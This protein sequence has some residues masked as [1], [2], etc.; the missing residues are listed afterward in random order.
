MTRRQIMK[1]ENLSELRTNLVAYIKGL[2]D[3]LNESID[4]FVECP[5]DIR[6]SNVNLKMKEI[7]DFMKDLIHIQHRI[8]NTNSSE[9]NG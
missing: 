1:R 7:R 2:K 5:S 9:D 3:D 4:D 6:Q 8:D